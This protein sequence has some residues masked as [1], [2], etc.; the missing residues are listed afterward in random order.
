MAEN[1]SKAEEPTLEVPTTT[2]I[3]EAVQTPPSPA[4][5]AT[6]PTNGLAVAALVVGIVAVVTGWIPFW[7][8][9][10]GATA[11]TLG[12]LGLKKAHGKGMAIAGIITGGIGALWGLLVAVFFTLA[13]VMSANTA[14]TFQEAIQEEGKQNQSL[15]DAQKDFN[16]GQ[17]ANFANMYEVKVNSV[18]K[19]F[20]AGRTYQPETGNQFIR[21]N[22]TLKNIS[23]KPEYIDSWRFTVDD[24]GRNVTNSYIAVDDELDTDK[25]NPGNSVT[26][27]LVYEVDASSSDFKLQYTEM[28]YDQV[29]K[30]QKLTYTLAF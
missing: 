29:Q 27:N 6:G 15:I 4:S 7:G 8:L 9:L 22:I 10:V 5:P 18:E 17:T 1:T 19:N 14:N 28:I 20:E 24:N 2:S 25:L 23:D 3:P 30:S 16:K 11:V 12:I 21:V 13:I 26:G